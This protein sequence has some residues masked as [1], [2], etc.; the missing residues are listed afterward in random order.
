MIIGTTNGKTVL[1]HEK[2]QTITVEKTSLLIVNVK[3]EKEAK[4]IAGKNFKN[5]KEAKNVSR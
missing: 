1:F 3:T 4:R 5:F 2:N